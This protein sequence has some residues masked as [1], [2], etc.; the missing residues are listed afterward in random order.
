[1][2]P[3]ESSLH[4]QLIAQN[5]FTAQPRPLPLAS[6]L[7]DTPSRSDTY[8]LIFGTVCLVAALMIVTLWRL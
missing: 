4:K 2:T 8:L 1:M 3:W 7:A 6:D 5:I